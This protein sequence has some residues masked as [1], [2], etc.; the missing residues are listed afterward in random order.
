MPGPQPARTVG[1]VRSRLGDGHQGDRFARRSS[2]RASQNENR[3]GRLERVQPAK[4]L[5]CGQLHRG[6]AGVQALAIEQLPALGKVFDRDAIHY[7]PPAAGETSRRGS[8]DLG[9]TTAAP[10]NKH[11]LRV[12]QRVKNGRGFGLDRWDL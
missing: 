9:Q 2:L 5:E 11:G 3:A 4:W 7:H 12:G 1:P 8:D 10:A 6:H